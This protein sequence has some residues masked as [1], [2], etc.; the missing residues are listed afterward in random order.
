[1]PAAA[2]G[3]AT[4][5]SWADLTA[6]IDNAADNAAT[7]VVITS[8]V[9][10]DVGKTI[11]IDNG[12][13][14][15]ITSKVSPAAGKSLTTATGDKSGSLFDVKNG[16]TLTFGTRNDDDSF[17]YGG[18]E[19]AKATRRLATVENGAGLNLN[20]GT[21][22]YI[23]VFDAAQKINSNDATAVIAVSAGGTITV[24]SGLFQNNRS[25]NGDTDQSP[26]YTGLF[27][28]TAGGS[29][30]INGGDFRN[31]VGI[32]G[33][34]ISSD[35]GASSIVINGG[36][37]ENNATNFAGGVIFQRS[38][39]GTITIKGD[40]RFVGNVSGTDGGVI[41]H[42][43]TL[44]IAGGT[45]ENNVA[46]GN[47]GGAIFQSGNEGTGSAETEI[48]GAAEGA[49]KFVNN[50]HMLPN[51]GLGDDGIGTDSAD[52]KSG[53]NANT[54]TGGGGGAIHT[55]GGTLKIVGGVT[56]DGNR[57]NATGWMVGG[58]AI[59]AWGTLWVL[60]SDDS[61]KPQFTGN[62]S[63]VGAD[64]PYMPDG[65]TVPNGGAGG[66]IFLQEKDSGS[67]LAYIMGGNYEKNVSGY[68][69][70]SIYTEEHTTA[71]VGKALMTDN[72]AG[73]FG[74]GLWLC[75]S[76]NAKA[77]EGGNAA[78]YGNAIDETI[79]ANSA[80]LE[81]KAGFGTTAGDDFAMMNPSGKAMSKQTQFT[82]MRQWFSDRAAKAVDWYWDGTPQTQSNGFA[83]EYQVKAGSTFSGAL[84][85][86]AEA[87]KT[88]K[89]DASFPQRYSKAEGE[90]L[91]ADGSAK[92]LELFLDS[93]KG[94][95]AEKA[96][97]LDAKTGNP[98][99]TLY[100]GVGFKAIRTADADTAKTENSASMTLKNNQ[101]RLSGGAFGSNGV[102]MFSTPYGVSWSKVS[103]AKGEAEAKKDNQDANNYLLKNSA[104]KLTT[105]DGG[106][107][108]ESMR[109]AACRAS[110]EEREE[111]TTS[112][113]W[114]LDADGKTWVLPY[115]ADNGPLDTNPTS[116]RINLDNLAPGTYR[117]TEVS[118]PHGY[119]GTTNVYEFTIELPKPNVV[120]DDPKITLIGHL[121]ANGKL[122]ADSSDGN[123]DMIGGLK[124]DPYAIGNVPATGRA[125][126]GKFSVWANGDS[127]NQE[128]PLGGS[129]WKVTLTKDA[130][131][132]EVTNGTTYAITDCTKD[133][134]SDNT[135]LKGQDTD[136]GI[137]DLSI[138]LDVGTY[139]LIETKAPDGYWL[140]DSTRVFYTFTVNAAANGQETELHDANN[141]P[142][143]NRVENTPRSVSWRK[144]S[145]ADVADPA[146]AQSLVGSE[147]TVQQTKDASGNPVTNAPYKV[148]DSKCGTKDRLDTSNTEPGADGKGG[149]YTD[150][151]VAG[152][153]ITIA[154]LGLGTYVLRETKAPF[155]YKL[156]D[157]K[158]N[159]YTFT[160]TDTDYKDGVQKMIQVNGNN[161]VPGTATG[162]NAGPAAI[163]NY[164]TP[165]AMLPFTGGSALDWLM[166]GGGIAVVAA[167][168]GFGVNEYRRRRAAM[169]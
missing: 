10:A 141:K 159:A 49:V 84:K 128:K 64:S 23:T 106:P 125:A 11:T 41:N 93:S 21:Y 68:L 13:T 114:T 124:A 43:G 3:C 7:A 44:K 157:N 12:K 1:M 85:R 51:C 167:A 4:V 63:T 46:K 54:G 133:C 57:S 129:E 107:L 97:G 2:G 45:F 38:A 149:V 40:A 73:H 101:A 108:M 160:I 118:A 126:W 139:K 28:Q 31:N 150:R 18:T 70:G 19:T 103:K 22:E 119:K 78:I 121:D 116:G 155:G 87:L 162:A 80:N 123:G 102:V 98:T 65:K 32:R 83:D 47:G 9:T 95:N 61:V 71:Y 6:C 34:V 111:S 52:G 14:I 48:T 132:K 58:G 153:Q 79:D 165:V 27:N 166:L 152:G 76:G 15:V 158:D 134:P 72:S 81:S 39:S 144:I 77:S 53:C 75:P 146:T 86:G 154:E 164:P 50:R 56:F 113:C 163:K 127:T 20:G 59:Y 145:G 100:T 105:T 122:V 29:I 66:A 33:S 110:D 120:P 82:V 168:L 74:G 37:F 169:M 109:P 104:W 62:W 117:L 55:D 136:A 138:K 130:S 148:V 8:S 115:A 90:M 147:W 92:P 17:T 137:G 88:N 67:S 99:L 112:P 35:N 5:T 143:D 16:S 30:V 156:P 60:N 91:S 69:G 89:R 36:T 140:P 26:F 96:D 42:N 161:V 24:E 25:R 142:I 94:N 131:G 151:D 135:A